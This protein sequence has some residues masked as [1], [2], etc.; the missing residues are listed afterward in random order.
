MTTVVRSI[1]DRP[2][3]EPLDRRAVVQAAID[4]GWLDATTLLQEIDGTV[5]IVAVLP[6]LHQHR[7]TITYDRLARWQ[8][9]GQQSD[10]LYL[11]VEETPRSC[12]CVPRREAA[13]P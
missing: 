12:F 10:M 4:Y 6:C 5:T 2:R 9:P 8:G 1:L 13:S 3:P 11:L 7:I